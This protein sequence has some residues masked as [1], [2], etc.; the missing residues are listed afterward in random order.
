MKLPRKETHPTVE[1]LN[2][3]PIW[4]G[5]SNQDLHSIVRL[6]KDLRYDAGEVIVKKG[7][8]GVG[9]YLI[10]DG[11]VEVK[12]GETLLSKLGR[13]QFFGEMSVLDD[14]PR[15]ADVIAV[16]PSRCLAL[17]PWGFEAL[18]SNHPKIALKMLRELV[19]RLRETNKAFSE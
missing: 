15:S 16:E 4:S 2:Q 1:M 12:S 13:G 11:S 18:V 3:I 7:E 6:A 8:S 9:F 19:R 14:E 17:T 5:L 10:L